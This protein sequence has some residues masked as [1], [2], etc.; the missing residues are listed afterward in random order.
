M[1]RGHVAA[2][3]GEH[4]RRRARIHVA[5]DDD[6]V[7]L[8][9]AIRRDL[10]RL[11]PAEEAV[12]VAVLRHQRRLGEVTGAR[13]DD[14]RGGERDGLGAEDSGSKRGHLDASLARRFDLSGAEASLGTDDH[15]RRRFEA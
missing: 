10:S 8:V 1:D 5:E 12:R 15:G 14:R 13:Q 11:E 3:D 6:L 2:R 7:V 4:V 9:H